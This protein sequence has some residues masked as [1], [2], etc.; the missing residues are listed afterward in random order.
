VTFFDRVDTSQVAYRAVSSFNRY[1]M[2]S[3]R[4]CCVMQPPTVYRDGG[5]R[6]CEKAGDRDRPGEPRRQAVPEDESDVE[7]CGGSNLYLGT[8][9]LSGVRSIACKLLPFA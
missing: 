7:E 3:M 8:R 4:V 9:Q 2:F 6:L 5:S 1:L